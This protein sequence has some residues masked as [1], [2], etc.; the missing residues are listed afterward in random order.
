MN[1]ENKTQK[2]VRRRDEIIGIIKDQFLLHESGEDNSWR[3]IHN[4][5]ILERQL[6]IN[7]FNYFKKHE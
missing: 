2:A 4:L 5:I 3:V 1:K 7:L 6:E